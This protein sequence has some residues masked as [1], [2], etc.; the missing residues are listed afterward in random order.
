MAH[1]GIFATSDE[2]LLKAGEDVSA[3]AKTEARI[4][5]LCKQAESFIN[6]TTRY[7]WSDAY[8]T[9]N[10]DAKGILSLCAS[11]LVAMYLI[12]YHLSSYN[13]RIEAETMLD[14]LRDGIVKCI[15]LL[16]DKQNVANFIINA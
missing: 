12:N 5:A 2:I 15:E 7:N 8:S 4:N 1:E 14:V 9:L 3:S 16:S 11:N 6:A 13:T 10:A